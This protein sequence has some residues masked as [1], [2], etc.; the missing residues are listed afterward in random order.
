MCSRLKLIFSESRSPKGDCK[1]SV[2]LRSTL[3]KY[4]EMDVI[5]EENEN[6]ANIKSIKVNDINNNT[7]RKGRETTVITGI[8]TN[9]AK[10]ENVVIDFKKKTKN[11]SIVD[12]NG[13]TNKY[14]ILIIIGFPKKI[15]MIKCH[16]LNL[17]STKIKKKL[18]KLRG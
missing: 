16:N 3:I 9:P 10:I 14:N 12:F 1:N 4:N 11:L 6:T 13:T 7:N 2:D 17:L 15:Q 8:I 18:F 5:I